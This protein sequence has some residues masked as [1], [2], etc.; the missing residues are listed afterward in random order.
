MRGWL[1][2]L[3]AEGTGRADR[4][5]REAR[6][7]THRARS[8][9]VPPGFPARTPAEAIAPF[10]GSPPGRHSVA[11]NGPGTFGHL[12]AEQLMRATGTRLEPDGCSGNPTAGTTRLT[13]EAV[14][15]GAR[16]ARGP[17]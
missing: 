4:G 11:N 6:T 12:V 1:K 13:W 15:A 2:Q 5:I 16:R 17:R 9:L 8:A 14:C 3:G 7:P 10:R